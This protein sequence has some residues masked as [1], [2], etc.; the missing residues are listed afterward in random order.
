MY[1]GLTIEK[2]LLIALLVAL[3]IGPERLP[4]YAESAKKWIRQG[5]D[6]V[7]NFADRA[8]GELGSD[9]DDVDWRSLDPRQYDPRRIIRAALLEDDTPTTRPAPDPQPVAAGRLRPA[10]PATMMPKNS[11][12]TALPVL[13]VTVPDQGIASDAAG[14]AA[15]SDDS[16]I[17]T[18][19]RE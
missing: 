11:R 7:R 13:D 10:L 12:S 9:F 5:R 18:V 14:A 6:L 3:I 16:E 8:K 17:S 1:F 4:A 15:E 2:L 19:G